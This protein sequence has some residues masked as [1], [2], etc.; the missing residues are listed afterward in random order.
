MWIALSFCWPKEELGHPFWMVSCS[1]FSW[2]MQQVPITWFQNFPRGHNACHLHSS[3]R[4]P[5]PSIDHRFDDVP[6]WYGNSCKKVPLAQQGHL[7]PEFQ[8]GFS[9]QAR[10]VL[11]RFTQQFMPNASWTCQQ[12]QLKH[13]ATTADHVSQTCPIVPTRPQPMKVSESSR[14][15]DGSPAQQAGEICRKYNSPKGCKIFVL[16]I[17]P[18]MLE[19]W[20]ACSSKS[21]MFKPARPTKSQEGASAARGN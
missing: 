6:N 15:S 2:M 13:G 12:T 8:A 5:Q 20:D 18:L 11:A 14:T 16:Q 1:W 21:S 9:T 4:S 7:W 19:L 10:I 3:I 17:Y